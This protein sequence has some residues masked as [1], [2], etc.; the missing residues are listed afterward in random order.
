M[1]VW[2]F[3][4]AGCGL[5]A[6]ASLLML[7]SCGGGSDFSRTYLDK[8]V[9][10]ETETTLK[11]H[12][13][14]PGLSV[15]VDFSDGMNAAYGSQLAQD[16]LRK[17][18]NVFTGVDQ[19]ATFFSLADS[20]I[21]P[22]EFSQTQIYNEIMSAKNYSKPMAPIEETL[23]TIVAKSQ[24]ALLITD[25]EEYN[26]GVIQQQNYAKDYFINWLKKGYYI[27]FYKIDYKEG[28]KPKHLYFTVFDSPS[29]TLAATVENALSSYV[30][31][32]MERFVLAGRDYSYDIATN[33]PSST[34]G[35]SYRNA[36]GED[37]VTAVYEDGK[38]EA[39]K[40]FSGN[41]RDPETAKNRSNFAPLNTL[42]GPFVQY[43]PLGDNYENIIANISA[44]QEEGVEPADRFEHLLS[45]VY[46]NFS[47]QDGFKINSVKAQ[48]VDF[49]PALSHFIAKQEE[50]SEEEATLTLPTDMPQCKEVL[51][52]FQASL[53]PA[54][55]SQLKGN[56]W[57][58]VLFDFDPRFKGSIPATMNAATDLLKADIVIADAE[59]NTDGL[60]E[61]FAWPGNNSLEQSVIQTLN[62]AEVNP[63]GSVVLTYFLK[64]I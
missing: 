50:T 23:K 51:D 15:Y 18:I 16:A 20:Q 1:K 42:Y 55:D 63:K 10:L 26:G 4:A 61:F 12:A 17:V 13:M 57:Y 19:K 54:K 27:T 49:S 37:N 40:A 8:Y 6:G 24:P 52:M 60:S 5:L 45:K 32:G 48:V 53:Q 36:N 9:E 47:V 30:G 43:Y 33:Y 28:G 29:N 56:G 2:K 31:N 38:S 44:T 64:V 14:K 41:F 11:N 46:V 59:P 25:F 62:D 21:T 34:Q 39:Y 22:L 35:G 7:N 3:L 58:E